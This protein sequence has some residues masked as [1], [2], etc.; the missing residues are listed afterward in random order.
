M[1]RS[2]GYRLPSRLHQR[3]RVDADEAERQRRQREE[4]EPPPPIRKTTD[5][6]VH[7]Y[8]ADQIPPG[9][10]RDHVL[11]QRA[12]AHQALRHVYDLDKFAAELGISRESVQLYTMLVRAAKPAPRQAQ[13]PADFHIVT[14]HTLNTFDVLGVPRPVGSVSRHGVIWVEV[15]PREP[16][17]AELQARSALIE[18]NLPLL[19]AQDLVRREPPLPGV[20]WVYKPA[21]LFER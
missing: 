11:H 7:P 15:P 2:R 10:D 9:H 16:T 4:G 1:S 18:N 8:V 5:A 6:A 17:A 12:D 19:I 13:G 14:L 20:T 3:E 21:H